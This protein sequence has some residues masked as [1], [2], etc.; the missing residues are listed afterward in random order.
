MR[1]LLANY[2]NES[3][4]PFDI[5]T[6]GVTNG[7]AS[8]RLRFDELLGVDSAHLT[9]AEVKILLP[10][11]FKEMTKSNQAPQWIKVHD[12]QAQLHDGRWLFPPNVSGKVVYL[13]R[14]PLDV[15]VS[16]A[17]HDGHK[18]MDV[19]VATLCNP[20]AGIG[21]DGK[22]QLRQFLGDWS[23][24][25]RSWVDQTAIP[26]LTVRYEDML[27]D[28]ARELARVLAYVRP[29]DTIDHTRIEKATTNTA[30]ERLQAIEAERGFRERTP[31][32][33]RFFRN[34]KAGT[35]VNHLSPEGAERLMR[36]H[37][38]VM[39]RFGYLE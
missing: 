33:E 27:A 3:D 13:I 26:V 10:Y 2:Y 23:H 31:K 28:T 17:F 32:Q 4:D 21:G 16:R 19:A 14:N 34:G 5:N 11:V 9:D 37:E 36:G 22:Q 7:I 29:D 25:V 18:D 1:L 15:A 38:E 24:H 39:R 30:F 8:S 6:A 12:A 20:D 35:W